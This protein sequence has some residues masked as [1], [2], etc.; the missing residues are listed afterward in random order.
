MSQIKQLIEDIKGK[1]AEAAIRPE[2]ADPRVRAGVEAMARNANRDL[3]ALEQRYKDAVMSHAVIIAVSGPGAEEFAKIA[4]YA[5]HTA[6]VDYTSVATR[7]TQRVIARGARKEFSSQEYF[8]ALDELNHVKVECNIVK[9]PTPEV[10]CP[11]APVYDQPVDVAIRRLIE[12]N[13]GGQLYSVVSRNDIG[14]AALASEF[15]GKMLPVVL[16]NFKEGLDE[17][18]IP[19]PLVVIAAPKDV[20]EAFVK[21][22]LDIVKSKLSGKKT[23]TETKTET[24]GTEN[25]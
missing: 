19:R 3:P 13:Y 17:S 22:Q 2:D 9:L 25:V 5:F 23:K 11:T 6:I 18:V 4:K 24:G 16:Y 7:L 14:V 12:N 20:T 15:V 21:E 8:I 10:N 1:R